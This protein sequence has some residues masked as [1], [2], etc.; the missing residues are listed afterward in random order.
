MQSGARPIPF[1]DLPD[2]L[3]FTNPDV[4]KTVQLVDP[5]NLESFGPGVKLERA[6]IEITADA[7]TRGRETISL[8]AERSGG[9]S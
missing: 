5:Y 4:P 3:T 1:S 6:T 9:A 2:L 8:A 7:L